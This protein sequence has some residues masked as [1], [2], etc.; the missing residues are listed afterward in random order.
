[1]F[2]ATGSQKAR[3][4]DAAWRRRLIDRLAGIEIEPGHDEATQAGFGQLGKDRKPLGSDTPGTMPRLS[5]LIRPA[6]VAQGLR[7]DLEVLADVRMPRKSGGRIAAIGFASMVLTGMVWGGAYVAVMGDVPEIPSSVAS[8]AGEIG[9]L[10]ATGEQPVEVAVQAEDEKP[11]IAAMA[12]EALA[13][14]DTSP[15][16]S[17]PVTNEAQAPVKPEAVSANTISSAPAHEVAVIA[18]V[19]PAGT[20]A[21]RTPPETA[22]LSA[23]P[24]TSAAANQL[25]PVPPAPAVSTASGNRARATV[26]ALMQQSD[27]SIARTY[28]RIDASAAPGAS[29]PAAAAAPA[30]VAAPKATT[31]VTIAAKR[32]RKRTRIVSGDGNNL[33]ALGARTVPLSQEILPWAKT[34]K[35]PKLQEVLPWL[36]PG[37]VSGR[38][39]QTK[40]SRQTSVT[41]KTTTLNR[42]GFTAPAPTPL[43]VMVKPKP[44]KPVA[45]KLP[46]PV[47]AKP[48]APAKTAFVAPQAKPDAVAAKVKPAKVVV[49][50]KVK[51][52]VARPK[53]F[54]DSIADAFNAELKPVMSRH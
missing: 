12:E 17:K 42:V 41:R 32:T 21:A 48:A 35:K 54:F 19:T 27:Q 52:K 49:K 29:K 33:M 34:A 3:E 40:V 25:A 28:G 10:L 31:N 20:V 15:A 6:K 14:I 47:A 22:K 24:V 50:T 9:S 16:G 13:A 39:I 43:S 1:M 18:A 36:K 8:I 2:Q 38:R 46:K 7:R 26:L 45:V 5:N 30:P 23:K 51:A 53:S 44:V 11:D 4:T 37:Y